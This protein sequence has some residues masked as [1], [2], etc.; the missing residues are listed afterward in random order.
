MQQWRFNDVIECEINSISGGGNTF[1]YADISLLTTLITQ[2]DIYVLRNDFP[3][4]SNL[5]VTSSDIKIIHI[6]SLNHL[7]AVCHHFSIYMLQLIQAIGSYE[8]SPLYWRQDQ[9]QAWK[10]ASQAKLY[11]E[12]A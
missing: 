1:W 8:A 2:D 11:E 9:V 4:F 10:D 12:G 5:Q 3:F 6:A 7:Y